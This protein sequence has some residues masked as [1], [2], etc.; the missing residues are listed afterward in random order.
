MHWPFLVLFSSN[1]ISFM[2]LI[3]I[4]HPGP[5]SPYENPIRETPA[6]SWNMNNRDSRVDCNG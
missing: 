6:I 2:L 1:P 5:L 3:E 4:F